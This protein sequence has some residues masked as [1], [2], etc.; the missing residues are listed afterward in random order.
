MQRICFHGITISL[1]PA[2]MLSNL[3]LPWNNDRGRGLKIDNY[4]LL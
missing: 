2:N 3:L 1:F 4:S